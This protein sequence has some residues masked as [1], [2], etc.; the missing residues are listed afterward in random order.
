MF[1]VRLLADVC[2]FVKFQGISRSSYILL[3]IKDHRPNS[4]DADE[5]NSTNYIV[6]VLSVYTCS[7]LGHW[8]RRRK[9]KLPFHDYINYFHDAANIIRQNPQRQYI[10]GSRM[11]QI[12]KR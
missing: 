1:S 2:T 4:A 10:T 6:A 3:R 7:L 12:L 5:T 11:K 9:K 8:L